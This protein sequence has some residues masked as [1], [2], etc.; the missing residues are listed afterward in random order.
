MDD[1]IPVFD[2][3]NDAILRLWMGGIDTAELAFRATD[4]GHIDIERAAK[5]GFQGGFFALFAPPAGEFVMP[6]FQPPY[7]YPVSEMLAYGTALRMITEQAAVLHRL[8]RAGHLALCR[9]R[10][11]VDAARARGV[12]AAI[13][14]IEGAEA[15]GPD[16]AALDVLYAAGLRSVG[17]VWSRPT[18]FGHGVPFRYPSDGNVGP[19]LTEAGKALVRRCTK[20]GMMVDTS[21][22]NMAGFWDVAE[23]GSP[24]VATHSN[25]HSISPGARNLTDDQLRA[26]GQTGGMAGLNLGTMYLREDGRAAPDDC[27][28]DAM[29]HLAH[30][31]DIAGEDHVGI[32]SDFDGAPRPADIASCADLQT[33]IGAMRGAGFGDDL[34]AKI[35]HRNWLD[36]IGRIIG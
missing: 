10:A 22:L 1:M 34:I 3:H 31:V 32:G 7:D 29:R 24:L 6:D 2:G 28:D 5:G 25:A 27:L 18:I 12:I 13:M 35:A 23:A 4:N 17:P 16:L 26:I 11:E 21:H 30:M 36:C 14:H 33:L 9:S 15:I 19:G 20:L 8:D